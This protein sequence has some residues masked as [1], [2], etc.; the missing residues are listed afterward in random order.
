MQRQ[1]P[2]PLRGSPLGLL[3]AQP[4]LT[5]PGCPPGPQPL[6]APE[7]ASPHGRR[8]VGVQRTSAR[9]SGALSRPRRLHR[10]LLPRP[11]RGFRSGTRRVREP[12]RPQGSPPA[13]RLSDEP[14]GS[15]VTHLSPPLRHR[16]QGLSLGGPGGSQ[17]INGSFPIKPFCQVTTEC[18][19]WPQGSCLRPSRAA[20]A[21]AGA[22]VRGSPGS[23][24]LNAPQTAPGVLERC[25]AP[26]RTRLPATH[27]ACLSLFLEP[28]LQCFP[29]GGC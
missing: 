13:S 25:Q 22:E 1:C 3:Q 16:L 19:F 20:A 7:L 6:C 21:R 26:V 11:Q 18:G 4:S 15:P 24:S 23:L 27:T 5:A 29:A 10:L 12:T 2:L 17:G 14:T 8:A 28:L 9:R